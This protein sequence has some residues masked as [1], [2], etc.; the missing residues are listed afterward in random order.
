METARLTL[1]PFTADDLDDVYAYYSRPD[2]T[3]FLFQEPR[4]REETRLVLARKAQEHVLSDQHRQM[5]LAVVWREVGRVVGE[6]NL[7][8]LSQKHR[9]GEIGFIF[10]PEFHSR[11]LATEAAE[12]MLRV[13]FEELGLHRIIGRCDARNRPSAALMERL[14]MRREAHLVHNEMFKGEWADE[15]VFAM[16]EDEWA[17]R[18]LGQAGP[19]GTVAS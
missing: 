18:R 16:L 5:V 9:R 6:V 12:A 8:W 19:R 2:V 11:G 15:L 3:R 1:R 10:N 7:E 17:P 4:D 14:G 13:G